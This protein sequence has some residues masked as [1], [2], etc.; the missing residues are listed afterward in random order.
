MYG[1][2]VRGDSFLNSYFR[3]QML[4]R[5]VAI[6]WEYVKKITYEHVDVLSKEKNV[7][8][9]S[10]DRIGYCELE[11][12]KMEENSFVIVAENKVFVNWE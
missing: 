3:I 1:G 8:M 5:H 11:C 10:K 2:G 12:E 7:F 6:A 9:A 4:K